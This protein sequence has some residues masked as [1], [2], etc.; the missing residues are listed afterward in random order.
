MNIL[1]FEDFNEKKWIKNAIKNPGSLRKKLHKKEDE[2]IS[3]IEIENELKELKDKD[4]DHDK[5]GIQGLSKSDLKKFKQ[6]NLAKTLKS[7]NENIDNYMFFQNLENMKNMIEELLK[8]DSNKVDKI[9]S[10]HDWA[11]D[12]IS[13]SNEALEQVFSFLKANV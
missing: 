7:F 11:S 13:S 8:M 3:S 1:N 5:K 9:L 6:L 4:K 12:H 2:K 10:E